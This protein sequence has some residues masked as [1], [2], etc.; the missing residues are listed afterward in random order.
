MNGFFGQKDVRIFFARGEIFP[1][2]VYR[3]KQN[4][5][6]CVFKVISRV[7]SVLRPD[8]RPAQAVQPSHSAYVFH[9]LNYLEI[10][11]KQ[12]FREKFHMVEEFCNN[13]SKY[14]VT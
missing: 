3:T 14:N 6:L 4:C 5:V 2:T 9:G 1:F 7:Y 13:G 12:C 8:G 10:S 11:S